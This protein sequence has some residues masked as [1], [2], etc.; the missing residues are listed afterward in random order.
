MCSLA[1][2]DTEA[3]LA[4]GDEPRKILLDYDFFNPERHEPRIP[5]FMHPRVYAAGLHHMP[6]PPPDRVRSTRIGF[7]GTRD[8]DFYTKD[9]HFPILNREQILDSFLSE[10]G[11][12]AWEIDVHRWGWQQR[13]IAVAID[14]K[15]GDRLD[16][17]FLPMPEYLKA[18]RECDFFL[19]P[20]GWCMPLSHNLIEGMAAGCIP[21]LNCAEFLNPPLEHGTNCLVFGDRVSLKN[22]LRTALKMPPDNIRVMRRNVMTYYAE[23]LAPGAWLKEMLANGRSK[24]TVLVNAE[25]LSVGFPCQQAMRFRSD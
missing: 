15:G 25:E 12:R 7:F 20:P 6:I 16:K 17:A 19:S 22:A 11:D 1:M 14:S 8:A 24:M 18:L 4:R 2:A 3:A 23:E 13:D 21:I 5:Y 9:F 10:F